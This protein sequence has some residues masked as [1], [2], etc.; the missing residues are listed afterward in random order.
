[1]KRPRLLVYCQHLLGIGHLS[2]CLALANGSLDD[3][4]V[5]F[6][7]G[8]PDVG[9]SILHPQFHHHFL[10][11][12]L[13]R[14]EDSMLYSP[15]GANVAECVEMRRTQL[16]E[17]LRTPFDAL[18][19]ELYP[20]GRRKQRD[21][22]RFLID[23]ARRVQPGL[24]VACSLRDIVVGRQ[25]NSK[26][27]EFVSEELRARFDLVLVHSDPTLLPMTLPFEM[28]AGLSIPYHYTGFVTEGRNA[29]L[30]EKRDNSIL[31]SLGGGSV[32]D[33]LIR[34]ILQV[35]ER[36]EEL[37]FKIV[38]SP[39]MPSHLKGALESCVLKNVSILPFSQEFENLMSRSRLS[40]SMAG[41]NTVMNLL[42]TRTYGLV[43]PYGQ[44]EEQQTRAEVFA[45][46]GFLETLGP[47]DLEPSRLKMRIERA[48]FAGYP[49]LSVDLNGSKN[50]AHILSGLITQT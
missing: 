18:L 33:E 11:P 45:R 25:D 22:I 17:I 41:Y 21:E 20:F 32:G 40:I 29:E 49:N 47:E 9:K 26:F 6:V 1:M 15:M 23:E 7:Q 31:V 8:G 3:F 12:L 44:N 24:K 39:A 4:E 46:Q 30:S 28:D 37:H 34:S 50:S 13:M 48:L 10:S 38:V 43:L 16:Q 42:N 19:V 14:E 35:A 27:A 36:A 2:R 5:S